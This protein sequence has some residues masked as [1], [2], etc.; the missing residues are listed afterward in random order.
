[1]DPGTSRT[2]F[3][4]QCPLHETRY[5][6]HSQFVTQHME[7][8]YLER[9]RLPFRNTRSHL[10]CGSSH[11]LAKVFTLLFGFTMILT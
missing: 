6:I 10:S 3:S 9:I 8:T 7:G 1:M 4:I 2:D 11:F 5:P